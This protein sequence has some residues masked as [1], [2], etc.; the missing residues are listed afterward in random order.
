MKLIK[1]FMSIAVV[2]VLFAACDDGAKKEAEA[3]AEQEKME[4]EA[5]LKAEEEAAMVKAESLK[6][7]STS[8][9]SIAMGNENFSTLVVALKTA[10]LAQTL[11]NE[12][13]NSFLIL[14]S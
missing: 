6:A 11:M 4:M 5:K 13:T 8:I 7:K 1:L 12:G 9:T 10:D 14:G 3:K 2:G